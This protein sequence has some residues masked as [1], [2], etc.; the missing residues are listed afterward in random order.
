[1]DDDDLPV[2]EIYT[3]SF[4][5]CPKCGDLNDLGEGLIPDL[6]NCQTCDTEVSLA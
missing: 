3:H 6:T 4:F 2:V 5:D 1:M